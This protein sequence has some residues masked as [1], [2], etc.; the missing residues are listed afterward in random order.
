MSMQKTFFLYLGT[1]LYIYLYLY[2][3]ICKYFVCTLVPV[4]YLL[5]YLCTCVYKV[6]ARYLF[7]YL[8]TCEVLCMYLGTHVPILVYL[9]QWIT[10]EVRR[11]RLSHFI[12]PHEA[13]A[14]QRWVIFYVQSKTIHGAAS[15]IYIFEKQCTLLITQL[16]THQTF[17]L[18]WRRKGFS[19]TIHE[20]QVGVSVRYATIWAQPSQKNL[21]SSEKSLQDAF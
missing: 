7:L 3:C 15:Q 5:L 9:R 21:N 8:C 1:Y 10:C 12:P 14:S 18:V 11:E 16:L 6:P 13:S 20:W 4:S 19:K 2:V 17:C